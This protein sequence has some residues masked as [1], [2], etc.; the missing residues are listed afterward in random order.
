MG[1]FAT[2][3]GLGID[4]RRTYSSAEAEELGLLPSGRDYLGQDGARLVLCRAL[5]TIVQY[6]F[7]VLDTSLNGIDPFAVPVTT[8]NAHPGGGKLGVS[9]VSATASVG[10]YFFVHTAGRNIRGKL[11]AGAEPNVSLFTTATGGVLDDATL[12]GPT[13]CIGVFA[14]SSAAS[15]SAPAIEMTEA[16]IILN[17]RAAI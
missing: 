10:E 1:N 17:N 2:D 4:P 13:H 11:A 16:N 5:S 14:R 9:Q 12:S 3:G 6:D 7:V 15:A 8:T